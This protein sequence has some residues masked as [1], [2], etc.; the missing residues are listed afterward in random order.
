MLY[1]EDLKAIELKDQLTKLAFD[2]YIFQ[3]NH[4]IKF[5]IQW[6]ETDDSRVR[7]TYNSTQSEKK[8]LDNGWKYVK[9]YELEKK[10]ASGR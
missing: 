5:E 2:H 7:D 3:E 10:L 9:H 6:F 8:L 4:E 1:V